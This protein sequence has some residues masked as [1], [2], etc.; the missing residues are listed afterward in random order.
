MTPTVV[1][2]AVLEAAP[3]YDFALSVRALEGFAPMAGEHRVA[4][5]CVRRAFAHPDSATA[6]AGAAVVADVR[7]DASGGVRLGRVS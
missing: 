2:R 1:H 4:D 5:G 7:A 3:P 6:A